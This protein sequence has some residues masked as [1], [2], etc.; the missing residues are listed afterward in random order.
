MDKETVTFFA[1]SP[2]YHIFNIDCWEFQMRANLAEK[3][4]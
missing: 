4:V 3:S 1:V 2:L